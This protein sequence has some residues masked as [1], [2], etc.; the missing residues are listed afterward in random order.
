MVSG[1]KQDRHPGEF[2]SWSRSALLH[3][4]IFQTTFS[5]LVL[6]TVDC[7]PDAAVYQ[8]PDIP[9]GVQR[10]FLA[11]PGEGLPLQSLSLSFEGVIRAEGRVLR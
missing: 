7:V 2:W 1:R 9:P 5:Y 4:Y 10:N 6:V 8:P 11:G 3:R